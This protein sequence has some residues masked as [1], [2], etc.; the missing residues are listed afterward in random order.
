MKIMGQSEERERS[1]DTANQAAIY[2]LIL[3]GVLIGMVGVYLRFA[4]N[5]TTLSIVSW[6]ILLIGA[7]VACKGVFKIL[8]AK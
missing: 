3:V 5:S 2:W 6:V 7:I 8:D 1:I 4:F